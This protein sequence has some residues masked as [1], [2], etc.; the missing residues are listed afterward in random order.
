MTELRKSVIVALI[1]LWAAS[2]HGENVPGRPSAGDVANAAKTMK[3]ASDFIKA[4]RADAA[5]CEDRVR[6]SNDFR[7][8]ARRIPPP[9]SKPG[10][11]LLADRSPISGE[12]ARAM[13]AVAPK[14]KTCRAIWE[15]AETSLVSG[16]GPI[17]KQ[18]EE[19]HAAIVASL[20]GRKLPWGGYYRSQMALSAN[21]KAERTKIWTA[22]GKAKPD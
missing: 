15:E 9:G 14:F 18:Y 20:V 11:G 7:P 3:D 6:K 1:A 17:L 10:A 22:S 19:K 2:A 12:E 16:M 8:L 4:K 13:T 5:S 21:L